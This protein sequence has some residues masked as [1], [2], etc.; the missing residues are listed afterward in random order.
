LGQTWR[1][2][3]YVSYNAG[4]NRNIGG[5]TDADAA[6]PG[7]ASPTGERFGAKQRTERSPRRTP[8]SGPLQSGASPPHWCDGSTGSHQPTEPLQDVWQATSVTT[9]PRQGQQQTETPPPPTNPPALS[10]GAYRLLWRPNLLQRLLNAFSKQEKPSHPALLARIN[11]ALWE[12][13]EVYDWYV[14]PGVTPPADQK[15]FVDEIMWPLTTKI[16][17]RES[18]LGRRYRRTLLLQAAQVFEAGAVHDLADPS[19]AAK[20][21]PAIEVR[22][23]QFLIARQSALATRNVITALTLAGLAAG[24]GYYLVS[25]GEIGTANFFYVASSCLAVDA[26]LTRGLVKAETIIEYEKRRHMLD[27]PILRLITLAIAVELFAILCWKGGLQ[28]KIGLLE[29]QKFDSDKYV[30]IVICAAGGILGSDLVKLLVDFFRRAV[31]RDFS[32]RSSK[33]KRSPGAG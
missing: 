20:Q 30:A 29:M 23:E 2:A 21:I 22:L 7:L 28:L 16:I 18:E 4:H 5:K 3:R 25:L 1:E 19:T 9:R 31:G 6:T 27:V 13:G 26:I 33:G 14:Q 11:S 24:T 32:G 12:D 17:R 8:F 15:K 10:P